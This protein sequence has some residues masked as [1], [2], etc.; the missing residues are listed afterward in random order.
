[1]RL[2]A[3]NV[4]TAAVF[5]FA[6]P[7]APQVLAQSYDDSAA[8]RPPQLDGGPAVES[9]SRG[10]RAGS[11][12]RGP[13]GS[14]PEGTEPSAGSKSKGKRSKRLQ[15]HTRPLPF[16]GYVEHFGGQRRDHAGM[17]FQ[18]HSADAL[19]L[20]WGP[21]RAKPPEGL[22]GAF[23][24]ATRRPLHDRPPVDQIKCIGIGGS[25]P[26]SACVRRCCRDPAPLH[27]LER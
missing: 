6:F 20:P 23:L 2:L 12:S 26:R 9:D 11:N 27:F 14:R 1:M 24:K 16:G 18:R 22:V 19:P 21:A 15:N 10:P 8:G 4:A 13:I 3:L 5:A 7:Q 25:H 17:L